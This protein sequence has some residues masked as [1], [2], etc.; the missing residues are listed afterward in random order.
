MYHTTHHRINANTRELR[1]NRAAC[2][3]R[4][5]YQILDIVVDADDG[6]GVSSGATAISILM[7]RATLA[8]RRHRARLHVRT[9]LK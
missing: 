5:T 2:V 7:R 3:S 1:K 8:Y 9:L 6:A 4:A